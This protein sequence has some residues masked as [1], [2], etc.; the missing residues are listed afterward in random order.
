MVKNKISKEKTD[1]GELMPEVDIIADQ[2][3]ARLLRDHSTTLVGTDG[4]MVS[5]YK[6]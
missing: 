1:S 6:Y 5:H 2:Y 3:Y 4:Y